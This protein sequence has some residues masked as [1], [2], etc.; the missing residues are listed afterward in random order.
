MTL[1]LR[2]A[3]KWT[4]PCLGHGSRMLQLHSENEIS[5]HIPPR[6][7]PSGPHPP[8]WLVP[9]DRLGR[10][11]QPTRGALSGPQVGM[12]GINQFL[13]GAWWGLGVSLWGI[14]QGVG[15]GMARGC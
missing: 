1:M 6:Q 14:V 8:G 3:H 15:W 7:S 12:D 10:A 11:R 2:A 13:G 4:S 9:G 5:P